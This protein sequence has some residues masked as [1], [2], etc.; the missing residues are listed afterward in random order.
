MHRGHAAA[1]GV[2]TL[3]HVSDVLSE[4]ASSM[5]TSNKEREDDV[6]IDVD[7]STDVNDSTAA[8]N[9]FLTVPMRK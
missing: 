4:L 9:T 8:D 5:L 2:T 1:G 3:V 6:D 7:D